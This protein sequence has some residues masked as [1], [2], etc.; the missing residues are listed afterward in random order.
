MALRTAMMA[1]TVMFRCAEARRWRSQLY[2]MPEACVDGRG[3]GDGDPI[4]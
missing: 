3:I 1:P 4:V 2:L